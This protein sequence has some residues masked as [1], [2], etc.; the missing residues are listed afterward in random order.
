[1]YTM[2]DL[3]VTV[4]VLHGP[5]GCNFRAARLLERDGVAIVTTAIDQNAVIFGAE[6][7]L[8]RTLKIVEETFAPTAVGVIG[9]CCAAIIG[10]DLHRAADAANLSCPVLVV[11]C[12]PYHHD[13]VDG[14]IRTLEAAASCGWISRSECERQCAALRAA[15]SDEHERGTARGGYM[16]LSEGD[17]PERAAAPLITA[18]SAGKPVALVLNA[19]KETSQLY[20]DAIIGAVALHRRMGSISPLTVIANIDADVGLPLIRGYASA[21]RSS[22]DD[23]GI[24]VHHVTGGLDEYPFSGKRAAKL[25]NDHASA[26]G[27]VMVCGLPHAV[28]ISREIPS[29]AVATGTRAMHALRECGYDAVVDEDKAHYSVLGARRV[30]PSLFGRYLGNGGD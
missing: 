9:T 22:F 28:P 19:K 17:S 6:D 10:E 29:I 15:T 23:E 5:A 18:F 30:V 1:M 24:P 27:C 16:P 25:I 12:D 13:N 4:I 2:R 26:W 7:T 8:T 14:A 21:I 3:G 20:A 11:D